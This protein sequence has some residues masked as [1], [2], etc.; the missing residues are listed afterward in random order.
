VRDYFDRVEHELR[1]ATERRVAPVPQSRRKRPTWSGAVV[2]LSVGAA[3][4]I[5]LLALSLHDHARQPAG[6]PKQPQRDL[7]VERHIGPT[8][9]E[10]MANF[11]LLRRSPTAAERAAVRTFTV[12]TARQPEVPEYVRLAGVVDGIRVYFVVYPVFR[13]GASGPVVAHQMSVIASAG[14][15]YAPGNYLIF[16]TVI[17]GF[18]K[19][20]AYLSVV[21]DGVRDVRWRFACPTGP[22]GGGCHLPPERLAHVTV[23]DN[24]AVLPLPALR[25]GTHYASPAVVTWYRIDGSRTVFTNQDEAVPFPSAPAWP[26]Q[27][28]VKRHHP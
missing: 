13:H 24:L 22:S 11:A 7:S 10:L 20:T 12:S 23:H 19:P 4:L 16:P 3:L 21:P 9:R 6:S 17:G 18:G 26:Y 1:L 8:L 2:T 28:S 15:T 14:N 25:P 5:A 27:R